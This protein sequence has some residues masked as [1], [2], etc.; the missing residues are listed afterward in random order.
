MFKHCGQKIKEQESWFLA[1]TDKCK[2]RILHIGI[3]PNCSKILTL[4]IET[5]RISNHTYTT[6][7]TGKKAEKEIE[8][9]RLDKLY[10]ADDLRVIKGKPCGWVYGENVEIHNS[11]GEVIEIRQRACD[12]YGQKELVKKIKVS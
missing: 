6:P 5:D 3:C 9:C 2:D 8:L 7:K 11:S 1:N 4:L 10:T 12:Y